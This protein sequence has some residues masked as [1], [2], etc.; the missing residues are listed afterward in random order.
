MALSELIDFPE[1]DIFNSVYSPI[2]FTLRVS[3]GISDGQTQ[4][5]DD[6]VS[7]RVTFNP[8]NET[9]DLFE[10]GGEGSLPDRI[11]SV[12][13]PYTPF[14]HGRSHTS[15]PNTGVYRY[16]SI[17]VAPLM[18]N[19]LSY[20]LRPCS[21]DVT[22]NKIKRDITLSQVAIN[23][24]RRYEIVLTPEYITS[25]GSLK[26]ADNSAPEN[27]R[28]FRYPRV[29][30]TALS[31]EEE[32]NGYLST[33]INTDADVY[34]AL[35]QHNVMHDLYTHDSN[36]DQKKYGKMKYLSVK[37]THRVIG[38]DESEYITFAAKNGADGI[39]GVI[40]FYDS[41]GSV[42]HN[43]LSNG[44]Y[45]ANLN[46]AVNGDGTSAGNG[47][48]FHYGLND[49]GSKN[50]NPVYG[51]F[52][53]GVGTRN[54]KELGIT[55]P[56]KFR[57]AQ[58]LTDFSNVAYYT[59]A[60]T[61]SG[62]D[63]IQIGETITYH[64]DHNRKS[65]GDTV[66]FHWQSRLGGIDSYTFDGSSMRGIE[67][68]SSTFQQSI[69]PKFNGQL[70]IPNSTSLL[71]GNHE[72]LTTSSKD[73]G[74]FI[75]RI[76]GVTDDQ[77]P[78]IRKHHVDAYGNGTAISRPISQNEREM[79]EDLISSPNVWT[80]RGWEAKE[81][82]RED[83]SSYSSVSELSNNWHDPA[84][85]DLTTDASLPTDEGHTAGTK[86]YKKGN[87]TDNDQVWASSKKLFKY[88]P[89]KLYELEVR[90][91]ESGGADNNF[92]FGLT[93]YSAASNGVFDTTNT[94]TA[95]NASGSFGSAH[96][97]AVANEGFNNS[98]TWIV[99]RGYI[100]GHVR[101]GGTYGT[102]RNNPM[103]HARAAEDVR[104]FAPM[105]ILN[106]PNEEGIAFVDYIK[107]T[108]Y[109]PE[110]K[111]QAKLW[112]SLNRH[113]YVP[114]VIK[115]SSQELFN[116]EEVSTVSVNYVESRKKRGIRN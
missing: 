18:R 19:Y 114:V 96:Y 108:E 14:V 17:D 85:G 61:M 88:D 41:S 15:Q 107:V 79:M 100:S 65:Y 7:M 109:T 67:V 38:V 94:V 37:P 78:S 2:K 69:Y 12:R 106:H 102:V 52:Q 80:E 110:Q 70:S 95:A 54:I 91:K 90:F 16:F 89:N 98:D 84:T 27:I 92:Y 103:N 43:G 55:N 8:F 39:K 115:D 68:S 49:D 86:S 77:Y 42:I 6:F 46:A 48:V 32:M 33:Q 1:N 87:Q 20:N 76:S 22:N 28:K 101:E 62:N 116:S 23:L 36:I 82:F 64:I 25:S 9:F 60:T 21:H 111:T 34:G 4:T 112:S 66:R 99:R 104:F 51:V 24:F 105:F 71:I 5:V 26:S 58:P 40:T 93:G 57:N 35:L 3:G 31:Y 10:N 74:S 11:F 73:G 44:Y 113:Y 63:E 30:N 81:V 29:I 53:I 97:I 45:G 50:T 56:A 13:V 72:A 83:F 75:Q 47:G 59:V